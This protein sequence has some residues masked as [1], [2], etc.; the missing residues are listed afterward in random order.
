M[1]KQ[2]NLKG[3]KKK[4]WSKKNEMQYI[5]ILDTAKAML[6]GKFIALDP[7]IRKEKYSQMENISS[8]HN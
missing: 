5:K 1:A 7:Y 3:N 8:Y 4:Y 2:E 6:G